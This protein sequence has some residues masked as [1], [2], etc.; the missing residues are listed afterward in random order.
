MTM[1]SRTSTTSTSGVTLMPPIGPRGPEPPAITPPER[2]EAPADEARVLDAVVGGLVQPVVGDDAGQ[3]DQ[4]A[5]GGRHE[6]LGE[7][8]HDRLGA[9]AAGEGQVVERAH[10]AEHGA[11]Q[12]DEGRVVAE[13]VEQGQPGLERPALEGEAALDRLLGRLAVGQR[14]GDRLREPALDRAFGQEGGRGAVAG[15]PLVEKGG[16]KLR[17]GLARAEDDEALDDHADG[18]DRGQDQEVDHPVSARHRERLHQTEMAHRRSPCV[19]FRTA[20]SASA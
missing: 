18:D 8:L 19:S 15:L 17:G 2:R 12:A 7:A 14:A 1:M 3:S 20:P 6:R 11:E 13:R 5:D 9:R 4:D 16:R 10:D